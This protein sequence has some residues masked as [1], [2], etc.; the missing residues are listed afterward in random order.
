MSQ[1]T[2]SHAREARPR[3]CQEVATSATN[4]TNNVTGQAMGGKL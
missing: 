1:H 2:F 4:K 3:S